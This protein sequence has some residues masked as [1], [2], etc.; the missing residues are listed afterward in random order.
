MAEQESSYEA[1]AR[2]LEGMG[3]H[4][5]KHVDLMQ[6]SFNEPTPPSDI[7]ANLVPAAVGAA[8][9]L[10]VQQ[11]VQLCFHGRFVH[12]CCLRQRVLAV[13]Y[14]RCIGPWQQ[15]GVADGEWRRRQDNAI[16]QWARLTQRAVRGANVSVCL[17]ACRLA[18]HDCMGPTY[19][20]MREH[21]Q[22]RSNTPALQLCV[23][24]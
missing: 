21:F 16:Q 24:P 23:P 13:L 12:S 15:A 6:Q 22:R 8:A 14:L 20:A 2:R 11:A 4:Y 17:H 18:R 3:G 5:A 19:K 10:A 7:D 9:V 1:A